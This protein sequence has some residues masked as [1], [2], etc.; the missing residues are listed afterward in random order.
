[1]TDIDSEL[2]SIYDDVADVLTL[3]SLSTAYKMSKQVQLLIV[4]LVSS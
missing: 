4:A 3:R 1:M 2:M